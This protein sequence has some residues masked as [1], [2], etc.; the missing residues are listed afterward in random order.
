MKVSMDPQEALFDGGSSVDC[1]GCG[2]TW[3]ALD[4][5]RE[6]APH[7]PVWEAMPRGRRRRVVAEW[8]GLRTGLRDAELQSN[9][10]YAI[11]RHLELLERQVRGGRHPSR[12]HHARPA[13]ADRVAWTIER[14]RAARHALVD[15]ACMEGRWGR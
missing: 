7:C 3:E 15:L 9:V 2:V 11:E 8:P 1:R 10:L 6:H 4:E 13:Y 14:V 12:G 5:G